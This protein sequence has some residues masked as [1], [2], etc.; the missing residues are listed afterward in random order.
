M[1]TRKDDHKDSVRK[2][3]LLSIFLLPLNMTFIFM[4]QQDLPVLSFKPSLCITFSGVVVVVFK[5]RLLL[6]FCFPQLLF[7]APDTLFLYLFFDALL[8]I[9]SVGPLEKLR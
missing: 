7:Q 3:C 9:L 2:F 6:D 1:V 8:A 5:S 4:Q